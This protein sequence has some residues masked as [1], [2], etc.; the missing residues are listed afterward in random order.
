V[1]PVRRSVKI[2]TRPDERAAR[3]MK[4]DGLADRVKLDRDVPPRNLA[5]LRGEQR[6]ANYRADMLR[7]SGNRTI[8]TNKRAGRIVNTG[9]LLRLPIL[10][11]IL[12]RG[13]SIDVP[14]AVRHGHAAPALELFLA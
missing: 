9:R 8:A 5:D 2:G 6:L 14:H 4:D 3:V 11:P 12:L 1:R 13:A 7:S 10:Q